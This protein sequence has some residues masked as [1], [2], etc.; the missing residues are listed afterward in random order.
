MF[1]PIKRLTCFLSNHEADPNFEKYYYKENGYEY[2]S[3]KCIK[4]G[5][6]EE[7]LHYPERFNKYDYA[8]CQHQFQIIQDRSFGAFI[9]PMP[10]DTKKVCTKCS[11]SMNC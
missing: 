5:F 7:T 10:F 11:F 6:A 9:L 8:N 4:C 2:H 1:N 3:W